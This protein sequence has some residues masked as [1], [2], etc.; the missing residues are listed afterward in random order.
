MA[1]YPADAGGRIFA[2]PIPGIVNAKPLPKVGDHT[3]E[4]LSAFADAFLAQGNHKRIGLAVV[5]RIRR[6]KDKATRRRFVPAQ[7]SAAF[8]YTFQQFVKQLVVHIRQFSFR[9][10]RRSEWMVVLYAMEGYDSE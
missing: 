4:R 10:T 3:W 2:E 5:A 8:P 7:D 9:Y 1:V 6:L